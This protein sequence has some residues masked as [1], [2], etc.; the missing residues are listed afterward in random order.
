METEPEVIVLGER[1]SASEE[2]FDDARYLASRNG[3][4]LVHPAIGHYQLRHE[5]MGWI[6]NLYPRKRGINPRAYHDPK[7]RG[8]Y[9][10][11]P[12]R[13]T[14]LDAVKSAVATWCPPEAP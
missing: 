3:M 8:P 9:L 4:R 11:L 2:T 12:E 7:H 10:Q 13:W 1:A 5:R 14:L 6:L